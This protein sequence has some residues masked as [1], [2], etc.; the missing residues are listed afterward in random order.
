MIYSINYDK[1]EIKLNYDI[2]KE[3]NLPNNWE[4]QDRIKVLGDS[5][6]PINQ[7]FKIIN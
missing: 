4:E 6:Y 2:S 3:N 7:K 1:K 5:E